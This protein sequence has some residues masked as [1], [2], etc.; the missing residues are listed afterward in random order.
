MAVTVKDLKFKITI[1]FDTLN[2]SEDTTI[3]YCGKGKAKLVVPADKKPD[4][5]EDIAFSM[6]SDTKESIDE[7]VRNLRKERSFDV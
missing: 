3:T 7:V 4:K 6:W 2:N 5:R 1:L